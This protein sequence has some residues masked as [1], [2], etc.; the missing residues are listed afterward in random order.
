METNCAYPV[1]CM[2]IF[3]VMAIGII[4]GMIRFVKGPTASDRVVAYDTLNVMV[5][6]GLVFL[7]YVFQRYIYL[8]VSLLYGVIGFIGVIVIAR[9]FEKGI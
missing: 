6:S 5:I 4:F 8:D 1:F 7:S 9:Y 3:S 2:V